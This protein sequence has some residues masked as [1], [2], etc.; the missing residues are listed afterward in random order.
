MNW[1]LDRI[2]E[3]VSKRPGGGRA[4]Y[5]ARCPW[6][7]IFGDDLGGRGEPPLPCCPHCGSMLLE[8]P[9]LDFIAKAEENPS[10]YGE[11]G[12][13]TF[14]AAFHRNGQHASGWDGY[15]IEESPIPASTPRF[16]RPAEDDGEVHAAFCVICGREYTGPD[17]FERDAEG[18][19]V[20]PCG[21]TGEVAWRAHDVEVKVNIHELRILCMWAEFYSRSI[22]GSE[23]E[24]PLA[25]RGIARR[26]RDQLPENTP[27]T[28]SDEM[29]DIQEN[30]PEAE[31]TDGAGRV[32]RKGGKVN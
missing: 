23:E 21:H 9:A 19:T 24:A 18:R 2:K 29:D 11:G 28:F 14:V 31:I 25:V 16:T 30:F 4:Y 7:T 20:A 17:G 1:T 13:A 22:T 26:L 8:A 3:E 10:H 27:L 32:I 6:W 5:A 15:D 12:L